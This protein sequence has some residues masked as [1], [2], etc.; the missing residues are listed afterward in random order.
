MSYLEFF[1]VLAGVGGWCFKNFW[2]RSSSLDAWNR[3]GV[4]VWKMWLCS[5]L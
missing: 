1:G 4:G 2:N 5:S 3:S